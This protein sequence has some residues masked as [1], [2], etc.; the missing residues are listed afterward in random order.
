[1]A[2]REREWLKPKEVAAQKGVSAQA[3]TAAIR[4]GRLPAQDGLVHRDDAAAWQPTGHRPK[5]PK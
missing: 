4:E 2:E 3:V 5:K 1:M